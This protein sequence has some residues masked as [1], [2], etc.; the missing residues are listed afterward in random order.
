MRGRG[1]ILKGDFSKYCTD[2]V[3]EQ[4]ERVLK[5]LIL[6]DSFVFYGVLD[7]GTHKHCSKK[8]SNK[9]LCHAVEINYCADTYSDKSKDQPYRNKYNS[10]NEF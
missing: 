5:T 7:E 6:L 8:Q 3:P 1:T 4:G 9:S 2:F 10:S